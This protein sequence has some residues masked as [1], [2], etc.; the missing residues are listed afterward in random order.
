MQEEASEESKKIEK[1]EELF[2][3][4]I[5]DFSLFIQAGFMAIYQADEDS[6]TKLFMAAQLLRPDHPIPHIGYGYIALYKL[7]SQGV[8][9]AT[10]PVLEKEPSHS[11]ARTLVALSDLLEGKED[12]TLS[13]LEELATVAKQSEDPLI[14]KIFSLMTDWS[15]E[16]ERAR[17]ENRSPMEMMREEQEREGE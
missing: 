14:E 2:F 5:E 12:G 17:I 11:V 7:D 13:P 9:M 4:F 10:K 3:P 6:A 8:R 1:K 15:K 16:R